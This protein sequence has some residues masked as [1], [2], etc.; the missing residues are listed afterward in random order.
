ML[1]DLN[2]LR[3]WLTKDIRLKT[4]EILTLISSYGKPTK[5]VSITRA[6]ATSDPDTSNNVCPYDD[7]DHSRSLQTPGVWSTYW[8]HNVV[9]WSTNSKK[10][11]LIMAKCRRD[12]AAISVAPSTPDTLSP[13]LPYGFAQTFSFL[14]KA[15]CG[16]RLSAVPEVNPKIDPF[17]APHTKEAYAN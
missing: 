10:R 9:K 7:P 1:N 17:P 4:H 16:S 12:H 8:R 2:K 11:N 3:L 15:K 14:A 5:Y 13:V 6:T